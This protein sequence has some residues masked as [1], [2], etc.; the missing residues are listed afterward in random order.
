MNVIT[1]FIPYTQPSLIEQP[2]KCSLDDVTELAK[3][4][5]VFHIAFG[6]QRFRLTLTQ[7]FTNFFLGVIGTIRQHFIRTLARTSP[8]LLNRWNTIHQGNSHLRIMNI[9]TG[10]LNRQWCALAVHNQVTL[11]AIF[12][13]IRWIRACFLPPK[14]AR[15]E[16]LSMAEVDQS[17]ASAMPN[18]SNRICHI[19]C[20][21]PAACQSRKRR[22]QVMPLPQPISLGRYSQ[23]VPV[24][25]T[26]RMPVRHARF[27]T[28]GRPP[29]G[30]GGSGGIWG[31]IRCHSSS[32][33]SGLAI[34]MSSITSG[35]SS[36]TKCCFGQITTQSLGFVRVP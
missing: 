25:R 3:T 15:T 11:R 30:L 5:T 35:Y 7:R 18:S 12:A 26:N 4:T 17:I 10:V 8:R 33:S 36:I 2:I 14:R 20:Q 1:F 21:T 32:V 27:D 24:L 9:G 16:Q 19:F 13:P 23:G 22:Q 6:D 34:I 31:L 28:R 29:L